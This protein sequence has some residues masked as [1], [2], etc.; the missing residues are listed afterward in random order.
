M[1]SWKIINKPGFRNQIPSQEMNA[2]SN[3]D[4]SMSA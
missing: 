4:T 1:Y 3:P 2:I